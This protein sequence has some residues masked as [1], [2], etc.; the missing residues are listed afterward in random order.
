MSPSLRSRIAM[1]LPSRPSDICQCHSKDPPPWTGEVHGLSQAL[2]ST[3]REEQAFW[4]IVL[5]SCIFGGILMTSQV[6]QEYVQG[7]TVTSTTIKLVNSMEFP[8]IVVCPK[9][10]D[11]FDFPAIL[12]DIRNIR[13][14][15][16]EDLARDVI[17]YFVAGNGLENMDDIPYYNAS[18]LRNLSSIYR[19]WSRGYTTLEFF[20]RI[21]SKF[22]YKCEDFFYSCGLGTTSYN[23]CTEIFQPKYVMRRGLC[24]ETVRRLNQTEVGDIGRLIVLL[25]ALPSVTGKIYNYTQPQVIVYVNDNFD[26]I[27][28]FPRYYLY[29]YEW[30]QMRLTARFINLISNNKDCT[31]QIFGQDA[32]CFVRNWLDANIV[33]PLNCT[34]PYMTDIIPNT[35]ICEHDVVIPVYYDRIQLVQSGTMTTRDV[36]SFLE[37]PVHCWSM[38][39][40]SAV[41]RPCTR[42]R[43]G[44]RTCIPGCRRWEYTVN[45]QQAAALTDFNGHMF[46]LEISF[47]N[48]Q[49]ENVREI[50]ATSVPSFMSQIGGQFG[51]FLGL[52]II[53]MLQIIIT[54]IRVTTL[55][56][57]RQAVIIYKR[58]TA[59]PKPPDAETPT[60]TGTAPQNTDTVIPEEPEP[61]K[62]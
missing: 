4:W 8:P 45:L 20:D 7:P 17:A 58:K 2:L 62:S 5:I 55:K 61:L 19:D 33:T 25:K 26:Y 11:A 27:V 12:E 40:R 15:L 1:A 39:R 37:I 32:F 13:P 36:I 9:I 51:F 21:Q 28:D 30:N 50:Y 41:Y 22:G 43:T 59:P 42:Y 29:P 60:D 46:N 14:N 16:E 6:I 35:T 23:C 34:L 56:I 18:Y 3:T 48:L 10:P 54:I 52:S 38:Y 49:Y 44:P 31:D 47:F 53:T 57:Y 24:Y